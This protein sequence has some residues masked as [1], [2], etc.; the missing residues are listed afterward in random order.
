[1]GSAETLPQGEVSVSYKV[2]Y[3]LYEVLSDAEIQAMT[4]SVGAGHVHLDVIRESLL[5][6]FN[7]AFGVTDTLQLEVGLLGRYRAVAAAEGHTHGDL[8]YGYHSFGDINGEADT[9]VSGKFQAL[10]GDSGKLALLAG[11]KLPTGKT[12]ARSSEDNDLLGLELQPGSGSL[13]GSFGLAYTLSLGQDLSLDADSRYTVRGS[14]E[15][16]RAG[17]RFDGG[18]SLGYRFLR[19]EDGFSL[20]GFLETNVV[21]LNRNQEVED[22]VWAEE[23]NTGGLAVFLSPG[24]RVS[25]GKNFSGALSFQVPVVQELNA[26]QQKTDYKA[27]LAVSTSF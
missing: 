11:L 25:V 16:F 20:G 19:T 7:I 3:T 23:D 8:S 1:V 5:Q 17:D 18:F 9:W 21:N 26:P 14:H 10:S 15:T 2:D 24:L 22:G 4:E 12:D 13:D 27:S 6:N